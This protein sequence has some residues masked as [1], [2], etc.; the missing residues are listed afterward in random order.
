MIK[1][2]NSTFKKLAWCIPVFVMVLC[3][4]YF[5]GLFDK[6]YARDLTRQADEKYQLTNF[7]ERLETKEKVL[8]SLDILDNFEDT[9][10]YVLD[11]NLEVIIDKYHTKSC[12]FRFNKHPY[13]NKEIQKELK[14]NKKGSFIYNICESR[15]MYWDY[16]WL[17]VD[18]EK[19]L[20]MIGVT[21]YPLDA[22]D[23][24]LQI[25]IGVLLM[26]TAFFNWLLVGYA[27]HINCSKK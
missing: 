5:I 8:K 19:L 6:M 17:D 20:V 3:A 11:E 9:H 23:K 12:P 21:N 14:N 18:N 13:E 2:L 7:V 15:P 4:I 26:L 25:A 22:I 16:R 10:T 1:K 27:N 24:E